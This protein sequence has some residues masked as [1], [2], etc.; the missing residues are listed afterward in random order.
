MEGKGREE[1]HEPV[2]TSLRHILSR[3]RTMPLLPMPARTATKVS[4]GSALGDLV[5]RK[6]LA[7]GSFGVVYECSSKDG[8]TYAL[9]KVVGSV[10][11][12]TGELLCVAKGL[13]HP[14][15]LA[16]QEAF[17]CGGCLCLRLSFEAG[18]ELLDLAGALTQ[19]DAV[20]VSLGLGGALRYMH[21]KGLVHRDCKPEN[22]IVHP[23]GSP[24]LVDLGSMRRAGCRAK[25]E[26][27]REYMAPEAKGKRFHLV[28]PSLD[29]WSLGAT[30][31][32]AI[33][34]ALVASKR[35]AEVAA[36][37]AAEAP[38][39]LRAAALMEEAEELRPKVANFVDDLSFLGL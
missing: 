18:T 37:E 21:G 32:T 8:E 19:R 23:D 22:V 15:L 11:T 39:L 27:T 24:V 26:G 16:I 12:A 13:R 14:C 9:K 36:A 25:V 2:K 3:P 6:E 35:R 1:E 31:C 33:M 28:R 10:G 29:A 17:L 38:L 30:L 4:R 7:A 20:Q 34:G 5:L